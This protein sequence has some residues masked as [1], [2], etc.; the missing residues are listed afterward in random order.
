[1]EYDWDEEKRKENLR[2]HN[3]DFSLA[4]L[5]NWGFA[6]IEQDLRK[7]YGESRFSSV[8]PIG[9]RLYV[10]VYTI[11]KETVRIISLRKANLREWRKYVEKTKNTTAD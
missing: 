6:L 2:K 11:R 4:C 8:A 3:V 7:N 1:M 9:E 5:F 10:M